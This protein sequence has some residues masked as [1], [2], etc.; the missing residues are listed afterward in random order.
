MVDL[1]TKKRLR[2]WEGLKE[3]VSPYRQV[4]ITGT[5]GGPAAL[6]CWGSTA[7]VCGEVAGRLGLRVVRPVVLSPFPSES[8]K[9]A[10]EGSRTV[11][12]VEE[13]ATAQLAT[14]AG[15]YGITCHEK[16]LRHD[17]RPF[18]PELLEEKIRAVLP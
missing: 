14:L 17:G 1:M 5:I 8:L 6:L 11:I 10:L 18:T 3:A 7:G 13:N 9:Q 12:A 2:K 16:I 15:L 4:S